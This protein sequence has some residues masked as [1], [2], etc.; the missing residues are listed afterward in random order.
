MA[1]NPEIDV[2]DLRSVR[3]AAHDRADVVLG[4]DWVAPDMAQENETRAGK[5]R[6]GIVRL[7]RSP[8]ARKI[9]IFNLLAI[10]ILVV[11]VLYLNPSRDNLI[12]QR[13]NGLV[14]EAELIA[15]VL[16]AQLSASVDLGSAEANVAGLLEGLDLRGGVEV[17]VVD[18][19][20]AVV[21]ERVAA[22]ETPAIA[23]LS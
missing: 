5:P 8:L 6:R 23:G 13:A 14:N 2:R 3:K 9:I 1:S 19:G 15:D 16:E 12:F 22:P 21:A 20:G 11:G 7:N 4:E 18:A 17:F 10:V